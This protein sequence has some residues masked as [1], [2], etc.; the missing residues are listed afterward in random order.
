MGTQNTSCQHER[1]S[2]GARALLELLRPANGAAARVRDLPPQTWDEILDLALRHGVAP[3][4]HRAVLS[5]DALA[6]LPNPVRSR[7]EEERRATAL[8]NLRNLGQFRRIAQALRERDIPVIALKGLHLAELVYRN[9]SLRPMSDMDILVPRS[10]LKQAVA[11]LHGLDYGFDEDLSGAANAMLDT[12]CNVGLAHRHMDVWLEVHWSLSEPPKRYTAVVEDIWRSAVPG[13]LGD[14]DA[15]VMSPEF[16]LLHVCAHLACNHVFLFSLR[17][18]CDIAEIVRAHPELDWTVVIDHGQRH[19]WGRGVA[20]AL[21]LA[22]EHLGAAVPA[23]V[24][25]A[26]GADALDPGMLAE[27]MKHL[28]TC[29]AMPDE[30]RTAPNL[31]ALASKH[32]PAEKLAV[33]WGRIF[34]PRAELALIYG[35]PESSARLALYYAV[36]L[37]DL[38]RRYAAS[39][40]A[41]NV[42]GS[43]LAAAAASHARLARWINDA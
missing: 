26:L 6:D 19:G 2:P 15:L 39:A 42:S 3:L 41:L 27:A 18:L 5:R 1:L 12:K 35:V 22:G 9:I 43:Q 25:A 33:L 28:V 38:L 14:A 7:L 29:V 34:V 10:Q 8:V 24:L 4:L 20:A 17:A 11:T 23:D 40:G 31:V 30:L 21:R 32:G 37:R 13:R 16:L 36:R